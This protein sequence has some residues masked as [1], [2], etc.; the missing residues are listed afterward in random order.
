MFETGQ[1]WKIAA[2][3]TSK[4]V[5]YFFVLGCNMNEFMKVAIDEAKKSSLKGDVPVGAIIVLNNKIIAKAH[6][7]KEKNKNAICHAEI[8]AINKACKKLKR[9]RLDDCVLYVTMEPCMMC[10]GAIIQSRIK[11][12][13]YSIE[14]SDFGTLRNIENDKKYNL[15]VEKGICSLESLEIIQEFFKKRRKENKMNVDI[16]SGK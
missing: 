13:V 9:W 2:L 8:L 4:Y 1:N 3:K 15:D 16:N 7:L 5:R 6:N 11:K 10:T 14:N 12:I